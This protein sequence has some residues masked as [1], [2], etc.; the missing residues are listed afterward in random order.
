MEEADQLCDR[1]G[2]IINGQMKV[3]DKLDTVLAENKEEN[4]EELFFKLIQD[5]ELRGDL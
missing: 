4:L 5:E 1:V 2:I 3:C